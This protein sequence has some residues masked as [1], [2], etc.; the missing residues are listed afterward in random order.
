[1]EDFISELTTRKQSKFNQLRL[2]IMKRNQSQ[3]E[4]TSVE[5]N[6]L[7]EEIL[8]CC[9]EMESN[10]EKLESLIDKW[11]IERPR[12]LPRSVLDE[13]LEFSFRDGR[14]ATI[15]K[16]LKL[17]HLADPEYFKENQNYWS[18]ELDWR[19]GNVQN[20]DIFLGKFEVMYEKCI[21]DENRMKQIAEFALVMIKDCVETKGE[22][23][24]IKLRDKLEKICEHSN[25]Y[26]L[27]FD[28]WRN[29]YERYVDVIIPLIVVN[30][31][32]L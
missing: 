24:V 9:S 5:Q 29:L 23:F 16:C 10:S 15:H 28:L 21:N 12:S 11:I 25:D 27:L 18:L 8:N 26:R 17:I 7:I 19:K 30:N 32:F 3:D 14:H 31:L 4:I 13:M 1:M 22:S 20:I 2:N 6:D